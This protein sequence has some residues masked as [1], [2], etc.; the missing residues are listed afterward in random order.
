MPAE[1]LRNDDF[2]AFF[3]NRREALCELVEVAMG[4][5][6]PRDVDQGTSGEDSSQ[7]EKSEME[8]L[9]EEIESF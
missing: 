6:V 9:R 5:S 4:K 1:D 2:A 8:E 7:F 3:V